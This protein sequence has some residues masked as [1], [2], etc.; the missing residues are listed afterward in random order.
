MY[1]DELY[2]LFRNLSNESDPWYKTPTQATFY[3]SL[4]Y[5]RFRRMVSEVLPFAYATY[6]DVTGTGG[7]TIDITSIY[8]VASGKRSQQE[9]HCEKHPITDGKGIQYYQCRDLRSLFT[10]RRGWMIERQ[11]KLWISHPTSDTFRLWYRP[12]NGVDWTR[13]SSGDNE[14]IDKFEGH[15]PLIAYLA[16]D[17]YKSRDKSRN[18]QLKMVRDELLYEFQADLQD[19]QYG[20]QVVRRSSL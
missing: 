18:D 13:I 3:L 4:A 20:G 11:S 16:F 6:V 1:V 2:A 15:H 8:S 12:H 7:R 14:E 17:Y 10:A 5:E 19:R 9:V